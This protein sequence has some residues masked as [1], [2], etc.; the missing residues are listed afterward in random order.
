M[1]APQLAAAAAEGSLEA[2]SRAL[3]ATQSGLPSSRPCH[4]VPPTLWP[5]LPG[6]PGCS[7]VCAR[8]SCCSSGCHP[9]WVLAWG[10]HACL[11]GT[12]WPAEVIA[13]Q[14][15]LLNHSVTRRAFPSLKV[16]VILVTRSAFEDRDG[17]KQ[18]VFACL[19]FDMAHSPWRLHRFQG[20]RSVV[21]FTVACLGGLPLVQT[22]G[23][24]VLP[25]QTS[26][27]PPAGPLET[28]AAPNWP[29]QS[30]APCA[31][32]CLS[33][34][35]LNACGPAATIPPASPLETPAAPPWPTP[36]AA[37]NAHNGG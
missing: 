9:R 36:T 20:A 16:L 27:T 7:G 15:L 10:Q 8:P 30:A 29:I 6:R 28:T 35:L 31:L 4:R 5:P 3:A 25:V 17:G 19:L 12:G 21:P 2:R 23:G 18:S 33:I 32:S 1:W 37:L 22:Y 26:R 14:L 34:V 24:K 11:R 13:G